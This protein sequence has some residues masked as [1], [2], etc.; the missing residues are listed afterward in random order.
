MVISAPIIWL[1]ALVAKCSAIPHG[2][3][4]IIH[5]NKFIHLKP[6]PPAT[7]LARQSGLS[8]ADLATLVALLNNLTI[9]QPTP[10]VAPPVSKVTTVSPAQASICPM[11]CQGDS[12]DQLTAACN[13]RC[14]EE[15]AAS[16]KQQGICLMACSKPTREVCVATC[17]RFIGD[18]AATGLTEAEATQCRRACNLL[19]S[20]EPRP[21]LTDLSCCVSPPLVCGGKGTREAQVR[22][23]RASC[24]S[25]LSVAADIVSCQQA[26][27]NL[28]AESCR[29]DCFSRFP[30]D[31]V[32]DAA[33]RGNCAVACSSLCALSADPLSFQTGV[34][35]LYLRAFCPASRVPVC[36]STTPAVSGLNRPT[37]QTN[38]LNSCRN[39]AFTT[40]GDRSICFQACM[41]VPQDSCRGACAAAITAGDIPLCRA[42]CSNLCP[43][44]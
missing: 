4:T 32:A 17:G 21:E 10:A 1:T 12:Q 3:F 20:T 37:Q 9:P 2:S 30:A 35:T 41:L 27:N 24:L 43:S 42:A 5:P 25:S 11:M 38:C 34:S 18:N 40:D 28:A 6:A 33:K 26:C 8:A 15:F 7:R 14:R 13:A 31:N 36:R 29:G 16:G 22:D 44:P 23:C 19:C 39:A